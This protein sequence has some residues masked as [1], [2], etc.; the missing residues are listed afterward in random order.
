MQFSQEYIGRRLEQERKELSSGKRLLRAAIAVVIVTSLLVSFNVW[1][2]WKTLDF[3]YAF[4]LVIW[5]AF[6]LIQR[7]IMKRKQEQVERL[8]EELQRA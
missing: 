5:L 3:F 4:L 7:K 2:G 6:Y 1:R 8:A